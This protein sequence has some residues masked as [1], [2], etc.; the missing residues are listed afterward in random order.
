MYIGL[1]HGLPFRNL[2][3]VNIH[4]TRADTRIVEQKIKPAKAAD[5]GIEEAVDF[6]SVP[7]IRRVTK[8]CFGVC[9]RLCRCNFQQ[10]AAPARQS[11]AVAVAKQNLCDGFT[12]A[13]PGAGHDCHLGLLCHGAD[14][15]L[16]GKEFLRRK[17][18]HDLL[19]QGLG[20][21]LTRLQ[22]NIGVT[23]CLVNGI[24]TGKVF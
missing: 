3:V 18:I 5:G 7:E 24:N 22:R 8:T 13:S 17:V 2:K 9:A 4:C 21:A 12:N 15:A 10:F 14:F 23:G 11:D 20:Q 1:Q 16:T 6:F 19:D